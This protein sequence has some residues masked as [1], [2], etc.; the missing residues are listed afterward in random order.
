MRNTRYKK[1]SVVHVWNTQILILA[2]APLRLVL[3]VFSVLRRGRALSRLL[4][5][6]CSSESNTKK[7][8]RGIG[9]CAGLCGRA[10]FTED[11]CTEATPLFCLTSGQYSVIYPITI[12]LLS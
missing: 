12:P 3:K 2:E 11:S 5:P 4:G 10:E 9:Q 6:N 7:V 8:D 1:K